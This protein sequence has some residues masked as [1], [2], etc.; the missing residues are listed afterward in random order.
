MNYQLEW[1]IQQAELQIV[2]FILKL[3]CLNLEAM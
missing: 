3:N 1:N 2:D